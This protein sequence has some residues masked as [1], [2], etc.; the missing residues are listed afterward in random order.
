MMNSGKFHKD[1]LKEYVA[2]IDEN[3]LGFTV[4]QQRE[5]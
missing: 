5:T 1:R 2:I 4:M 3:V